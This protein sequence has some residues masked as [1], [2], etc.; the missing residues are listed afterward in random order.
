M[1]Y[2]AAKRLGGNLNAYYC[3]KEANLKRLHTV[4]MILTVWH[5]GNGKTL[6]T[7]KKIN[8]SQGSGGGVKDEEMRYR[9]LG[10][11]ETIPGEAEMMD[12]C[13]Y[14]FVKTHR[15]SNTKDWTLWKLHSALCICGFFIHGCNK[16][17]IKKNLLKNPKKF[18]RA[19]LEFPTHLGN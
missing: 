11:S 19:K 3:R 5:S 17:Q 1:S 18:Q 8:V 7:V 14:T 10:G 4:Y 6:E 15:M 13:C 9:V 2:Q 12:I 16:P